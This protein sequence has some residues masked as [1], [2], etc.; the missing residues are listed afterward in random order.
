MERTN[1]IYIGPNIPRLGLM[2]NQLFL[3]NHP[4]VV[5][6][7][8]ITED[9]VLGCLYITTGKLGAARISLRNPASIESIAVKRLADKAKTQ[10][11]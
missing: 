4:P 6:Q 9:P 3:G 5:L 11:T 8:M 10:M 2:T 7:Q 1:Y